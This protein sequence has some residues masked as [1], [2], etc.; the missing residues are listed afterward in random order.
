MHGV[1]FS[2]SCFTTIE[3]RPTFGL[4]MQRIFAL[5]ASSPPLRRSPRLLAKAQAASMAA[6][7]P[8]PTRRL[9]FTA[10]P[11]SP[12][13]APLSRALRKMMPTIFSLLEAFYFARQQLLMI[14]ALTACNTIFCR[15]LL[16][17]LFKSWHWQPLL[18][19]ARARPFAVAVLQTSIYSWASRV[20]S[21]HGQKIASRYRREA[22]GVWDFIQRCTGLHLLGTR[23]IF[24]ARGPSKT[25][26]I[27]SPKTPRE[28][29]R[30][31][32]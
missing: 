16:T 6:S 5:R 3:D 17:S 21:A 22:Q 15:W 8:L 14:V 7:S 1:C 20:V 29:A 10:E 12:H 31:P 19:L 28:R 32:S 18:A 9:G 25:L 30:S 26:R 23:L 27:R 11:F 2:T 13:R 4:D 24:W